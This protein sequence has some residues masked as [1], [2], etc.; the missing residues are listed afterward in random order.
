MGLGAIRSAL[1]IEERFPDSRIKNLP[2][3]YKR[4]ARNRRANKAARIARRH[5]RR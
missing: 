3:L 5:N 1:G 2:M 4:R